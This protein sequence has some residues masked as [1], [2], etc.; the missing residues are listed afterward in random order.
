MSHEAPASPQAPPAVTEPPELCY[1]RQTR[2]GVL[3]IA[4]IAGTVAVITL[5][6]VIIAGVQL[7]S[8]RHSLDSVSTSTSGSNC[9][10]Q[11]GTNT[12]C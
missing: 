5:V 8:L 3:F 12:N 6:G 9:L 10:S 11:G 1:A 2:N 4:V 7:A